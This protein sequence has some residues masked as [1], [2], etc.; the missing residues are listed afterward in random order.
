[1]CLLCVD[2]AW[3]WLYHCGPVFLDLRGWWCGQAAQQPS[4]ACLN[5][6]LKAVSWWERARSCWLAGQ[7]NS[8]EEGH[9]SRTDHCGGQAGHVKARS[10]R[11]KPAVL[12]QGIQTV[13]LGLKKQFRVLETHHIQGDWRKWLWLVLQEAQSSFSR[14]IFIQVHMCSESQQL[15]AHSPNCI[16]RSRKK[17]LRTTT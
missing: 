14:C 7:G 9:W 6:R 8:L 16:C 11:G 4:L 5:H 2:T 3:L 1:M 10:P 13:H 15:P 12:A 17:T